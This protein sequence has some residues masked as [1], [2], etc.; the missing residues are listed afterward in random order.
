M[1]D[2]GKFSTM[3]RFAKRARKI[4]YGYDALAYAGGIKV[5]AV[6]DTASDNLKDKMQG[7]AEK[8]GLPLLRATAL[9]E[10]AG[11]N[12]KAVGVTDDGMAREMLRAAETEPLRIAIIRR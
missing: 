6:S 11:G 4:V 12:C 8:R 3:L 9:E 5:L 2:N 1:T 10:T 7:L